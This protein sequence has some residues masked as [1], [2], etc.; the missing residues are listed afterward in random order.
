M[1]G[2]A[3]GRQRGLTRM[4]SKDHAKHMEFKKKDKQKSKPESAINELRPST[5]AS[6]KLFP[7]E[8]PPK[9]YNALACFQDLGFRVL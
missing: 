9:S 3:R 5:P 8:S 6:A 2:A 1:F 7:L 4:H